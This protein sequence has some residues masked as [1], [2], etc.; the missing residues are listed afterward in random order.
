ME[1]WEFNACVKAYN[2]KQSARAKDMLAACWQ[3][4]AFA[5]AAFAGKLRRLDYYLKRAKRVAAPKVSKEEFERKLK[6]AKR[7]GRIG[8]AGKTESSN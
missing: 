7:G 1:L 3:A 4:A 8:G 5:G 2:E 6:L